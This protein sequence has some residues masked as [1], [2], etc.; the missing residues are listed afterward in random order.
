MSVLAI[1]VTTVDDE[2][3]AHRLAEAALAARL[4][5][6]VQTHDIRS[7]YVWQGEHR[8][9]SEVQLQ[10]KTTPERYAALAALVSSLHS[11]ETPEILRIDVSDADP[12]YLAWARDAT[13]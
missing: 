11:Y 9:D 2:A 6:C 3:Q 4:A 5:A 1:L 8:A 12:R 7:F 13:R 10:M